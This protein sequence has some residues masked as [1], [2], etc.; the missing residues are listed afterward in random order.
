[1]LRN[2]RVKNFAIIDEAELQFSS[3]LNIISGET[4]AGKSI[5]MD[6]LLL[7][8]GGRASADLIRHGAEEATVEAL[9]ELG[10]QSELSDLL[11]ELGLHTED[12]DLIVRRIVHRSGKNRIFVNGSPLNLNQLYSITGKLV[13]LCSQQDQQQLMHLDRQLLWV[14]RFAHLSPERKKVG[15]VYS[16]WKQAVTELETV[17]MAMAAREQRLDFLR[18]Q[19]NELQ[20][21]N[22][23]SA[24]EDGELEAEL[25]RLSQGAVLHAICEEAIQLIEGSENSATGGWGS[26]ISLLSQKVRQ[27]VSVDEKLNLPLDLL[28]QAKVLSEELGLF[29]RDYAARAQSDEGRIEEINGRLML[30]N[31]LKKKFGRD[32]ESVLEAQKSMAK[33]LAGLEAQ[34]E[35]QESLQQKVAALH[36]HYLQLAS[37]LSASRKRAAKD[38]SE[39]VQLEL[40]ELNMERAQ[41]FIEIYPLEKP[42]R[43]GMD[44]IRFEIATNAG[45][46]VAALTKIA[47]GGELSRIML[48]MHGAASSLGGVGVFLFDEV[49]A[50]IGGHTAL[51]VG[52]KLKKVAKNNQVICITHLPQVAAQGETH[53]RVEK[54]VVGKGSLERTTAEVSCLASKER[55]VELARMLGG[56]QSKAALANAKELLGQGSGRRAP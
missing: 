37:Q 53:F 23:S 8:L 15:Q 17:E 7:I 2:L 55:V 20:E 47:S 16:Q 44:Q 49:D 3:G 21:A 31:R 33:E 24:Q 50:G 26:G 48:A 14:D 45:E 6:A 40:G 19:L 11:A 39:K 41:F 22:V 4:G 38:L 9:F 30:L 54:R 35:S 13:D 27:L 36:E 51:K 5:L 10:D 25:K 42:S 1:M 46:P 29:F 34:S 12:G 18:F 56:A 52:A 43:T 28:S 32:L